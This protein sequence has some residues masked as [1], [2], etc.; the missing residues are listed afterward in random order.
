[1]PTCRLDER[2]SDV[3]ARVR[4]AGWDTCFVVNDEKVVLGRLGRAALA[5]EDDVSVEEAMSAGPSTVRPS[6]ELDRA[7]ERMRR[8]NLT[9]LPVTTS[10]GRLLGLL[11]RDTAERALAELN[12]NSA[13]TLSEG[14]QL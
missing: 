7:V 10:E 8:Q 2:L 3:R 12:R 5:G 1:M 4:A 14:S 9:A 11:E 6:L 13:R